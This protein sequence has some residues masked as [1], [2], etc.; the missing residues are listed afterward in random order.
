LQ[1]VQVTLQAFDHPSVA[2]CFGGP[3]ALGVVDEASF[4]VGQPRWC[5]ADGVA[6]DAEAAAGLETELAELVAHADQHDREQSV[7]GATVA[8]PIES[9]GERGFRTHPLGV[10]ACGREKPGRHVR[11]DAAQ[12]HQRRGRLGGQLADAG[13]EPGGLL[14]E[15]PDAPGELLERLVRCQRIS[16]RKLSEA[17]I[18]LS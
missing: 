7:V 18:L 16:L 9:V 13:L 15:E 1:T 8:A 10:V 5:R 12:A 3:P 17:G 14:V 6:H 4:D 11:A 2:V